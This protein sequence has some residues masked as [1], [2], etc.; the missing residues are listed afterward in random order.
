ME[1]GKPL[2]V[3]RAS[4]IDCCYTKHPIAAVDSL[5]SGCVDSK[6]K[7]TVTLELRNQKNLELK[8]YRAKDLAALE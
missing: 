4:M 1:W 2:A 7:F 3:G 8:N 6:Q 5:G